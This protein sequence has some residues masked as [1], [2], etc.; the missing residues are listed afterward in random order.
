MKPKSRRTLKLS[1][2]AMAEKTPSSDS[3]IPVALVDSHVG[4][5]RHQVLHQDFRATA[6]RGRSRQVLERAKAHLREARLALEDGDI[7]GARLATDKALRIAKMTGSAP[8]LQGTPLGVDAE[9]TM[10]EAIAIAMY[11]SERLKGLDDGR[12]QFTLSAAV[13]RALSRRLDAGA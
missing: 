6:A 11:L 13:G 3:N 9:S 4:Q 1:T 8:S 7:T 10:Q 12:G 2:S 5:R